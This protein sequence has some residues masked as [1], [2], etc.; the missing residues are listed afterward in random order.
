VNAPILYIC[1]TFKIKLKERCVL[2]V[3]KN[4]RFKHGQLKDQKITKK[5]KLNGCEKKI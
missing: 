1:G 2:V 5:R 3:E 4:V